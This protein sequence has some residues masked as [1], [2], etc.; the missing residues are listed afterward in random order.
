MNRSTIK[1]P[2]LLPWLA[3]KAG[4]SDAHA[5]SLW[6]EAER[7]AAHKATAGTSDY[8]RLAVDELLRRVA[9]AALAADAA[10]FG[11]RPWARGQ[12]RLWGLAMLAM[13]E[14]SGLNARTWQAL[15]GALNRRR[16]L[17]G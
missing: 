2:K 15:D 14:L 9:E 5:A 7:T 10:S 8:Y 13:H 3:S 6:R 1:T 11:W 4:I 17:L 12:A 16:Q